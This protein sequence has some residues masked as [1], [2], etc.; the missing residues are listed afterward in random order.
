Q[1][2]VWGFAVYR[3]VNQA[4]P[5]GAPASNGGTNEAPGVKSVTVDAQSGDLVVD[6]VVVNGPNVAGSGPVAGAGQSQRFS[7]RQSTTQGGSSDKLAASPVTMSWSP[8]AG[9]ATGLDWA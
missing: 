4:A 3:G 2:V 8:A 1:N 5:W 6:G 7:R 9:T